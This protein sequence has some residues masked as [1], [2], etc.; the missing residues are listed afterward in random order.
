MESLSGQVNEVSDR[1]IKGEGKKRTAGSREH[2]VLDYNAEY[3]MFCNVFCI[4]IL[5]SFLSVIHSDGRR[6]AFRVFPSSCCCLLV[7]PGLFP[8]LCSSSQIVFH[9]MCPLHPATATNSDPELFITLKSFICFC[10]SKSALWI[11][12]TAHINSYRASIPSVAVKIN[13]NT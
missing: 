13:N 3:F 4:F 8:S 7:L 1:V 11:R 9:F 12:P 5:F 2:C 6:R 10:G